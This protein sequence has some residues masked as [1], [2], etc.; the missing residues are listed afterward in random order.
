MTTQFNKQVFEDEL[1]K[2]VTDKVN[3]EFPELLKS[4]GDMLK[5][6]R[7]ILQAIHFVIEETVVQITYALILSNGNKLGNP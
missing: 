6:Q 2:F 5:A 3:A 7:Q 1:Y 4:G